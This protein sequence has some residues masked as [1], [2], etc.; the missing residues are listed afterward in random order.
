MKVHY[1]KQIDGKSCVKKFIS[2]ERLAR[3]MADNGEIRPGEKVTD[4]ECTDQGIQYGVGCM[5]TDQIEK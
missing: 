1:K 2:W 4:M 5:L 3:F